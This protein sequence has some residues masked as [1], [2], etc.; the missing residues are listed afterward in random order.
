MEKMN[1]QTLADLFK[2]VPV[3]GAT[4]NT[5]HAASKKGH[6]HVKKES[7]GEKNHRI[8]LKHGF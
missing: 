2:V 4:K 7:L 6:K 1:A 5:K 8:F 3:T